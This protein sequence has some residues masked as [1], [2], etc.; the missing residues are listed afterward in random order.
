MTQNTNYRDIRA[1]SNSLMTLYEED[2]PSF[3]NYWRYGLAW[4]NKE[5]TSLKLGS[6]I[7]TLLTTPEL[8]KERYIIYQG[9][10]PK[11]Q[12][13]MFCDALTSMCNAPEDCDKYY[14]SAYDSVGFKRKSDTLEKVIERFEPYK[15]YFEYMIAKQDKTVLTLDQASKIAL[16]VEELTEGRYTK[17]IVTTKT[18]ENKIVF[19]QLEL[20]YTIGGIEVKGALD[21]V[22]VDHRSK[23]I[24]P[25]DFKSSYN[26]ED[27]KNSYIKYRYYRQ[28]SFYSHLLSYWAKENGW[29]YI[30][31]PFT[32]IVC[33]TTGGKHYLYRMSTDDI[34]AAE[35]GGMIGDVDVKGWDTILN[36]ISYM[37]EKDLWEYP[38]EVLTNNGVILLKA[39]R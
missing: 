25:Y 19:N 5:T 38:Y 13:G 39:F 15:K 24:Y 20:K 12:I 33:S 7:D 2:F 36:E 35:Q 29:N 22:I 10:A 3:V 17:E 26:V 11:G 14:K 8:F 34:I 32:F 31:E 16:I 4:P 28:G 18:D 9:Y 6:A 23:R 21:R 27:F 30:I 1:I 37:T